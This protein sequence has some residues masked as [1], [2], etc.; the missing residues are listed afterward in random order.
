MIYYTS[1]YYKDEAMEMLSL[2]IKSACIGITLIELLMG[3]AIFAILTM[4]AIPSIIPLV[5]KHRL[6]TISE[7]LYY[8]LQYARTEALKKNTSIY[9]SFVT[10]DNWCYG[11]NAGN[12]CNCTVDGN[13]ALGAVRA[14]S[15]QKNTLSAVGYSTDVIFESSH[16]WANN[17]GSLTFTEYGGSNLITINIGK[18]GSTQM[19]SIGITGYSAC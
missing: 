13:C 10:G 12:N 1:I 11:I 16:G 18:L 5:K 6:V 19:C 15:S 7:N 3:L 8:H 9:V 14:D 17:S 2:F 4:I